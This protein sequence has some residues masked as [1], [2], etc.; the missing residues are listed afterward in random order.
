MI[1]DDIGKKHLNFIYVYKYVYYVYIYN[2]QSKSY[3]IP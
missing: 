2:I 3:R 1:N